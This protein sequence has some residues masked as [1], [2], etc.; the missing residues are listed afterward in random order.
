MKFM[1][2]GVLI[3]RTTR[4]ANNGKSYTNVQVQQEDSVQ[5]FGVPADLLVSI[6]KLELYKPYAFDID[7][8]MYNGR[9]IFNLSGVK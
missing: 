3:S 2:N 4:Q 9:P 8:F 5:S 6:N 1:L 7:Y